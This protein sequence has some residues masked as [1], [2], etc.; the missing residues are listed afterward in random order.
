VVSR[1]KYIFSKPPAACF[2]TKCFSSTNGAIHNIEITRIRENRSSKIENTVTIN[3]LVD[4]SNV[5][6]SSKITSN[7]NVTTKVSE[8]LPDTNFGAIVLQTYGDGI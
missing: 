6:T 7:N 3:S 4:I 8:L 2:S 1:I 5:K